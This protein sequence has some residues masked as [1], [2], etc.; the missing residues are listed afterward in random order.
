[1]PIGTTVEKILEL[2]GLTEEPEAIILG[3]SMTGRAIF[4][5]ENEVIVPTTRGVIALERSYGT[6]SYKY[7]YKSIPVKNKGN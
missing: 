7:K 4:E 2:C 6:Y 1:M 5:P 3:G